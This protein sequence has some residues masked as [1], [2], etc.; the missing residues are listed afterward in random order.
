MVWNIRMPALG[1]ESAY[2]FRITHVDNVAWMLKNGMWCRS[3][4]KFDPNFI[5]IGSPELIEK[6]KTH[7][8]PIPPGGTLS[9]YIPFY[10]TPWSIMARKINTGHGGIPK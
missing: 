1:P 7:T 9:D 2:I 10:F 5:A 4:R 8:V 3:S 6:R